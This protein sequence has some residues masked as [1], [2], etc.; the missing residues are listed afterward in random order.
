MANTVPLFTNNAI[1][2]LAG[3]ITNAAT[4]LTLLSGTG[5]LFPNPVNADGEFFSLTL[6]SQ[7]TS[8]TRE[9]VYVTARSGDTCTIVRAQEGT[10]ALAW[11]AG[12]LAQH[13]L[14]A[15][16][17]AA[18]LPSSDPAT[19]GWKL[20]LDKNSPTGYIIEQW[21]Q[22]TSLS[23]IVINFPISFPN[24]CYNVVLSEAEGSSGTWGSGFPTVHASSDY[25]TTGFTHWSLSWV[26]S[27]TS[28]INF[29]NTCN[30]RAIGY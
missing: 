27:S 22:A 25:T 21:G 7:S 5:A 4:S 1:T 16:D 19:N 9:I 26:Q 12:D 15:G 30:W 3:G 23:G 24:A 20:Y 17:L 11:N 6:I 28:W 29:S 13:L 18:F 10:T 8:T 14:T 2:T